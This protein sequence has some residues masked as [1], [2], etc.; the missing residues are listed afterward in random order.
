MLVPP[1]ALVDPAFDSLDLFFGQFVFRRRRRH[2]YVLILRRDS[3]VEPRFRSVARR[4]HSRFG[5]RALLRVE[6]QFRLAL[7][8]V[9]PV[10][11]ETVVRKDRAH[12]A[13]EIN[14]WFL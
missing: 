2:H 4:D 9:R 5:E 13:V 1:R 3:L 10:T 11:G 14:R 12:I 7:I 8:L 6:T